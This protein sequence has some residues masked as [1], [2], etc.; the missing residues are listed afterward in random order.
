MKRSDQVPPNMSI[1]I[2]GIR[3]TVCMLIPGDNAWLGQCFWSNSSCT[4]LF[5]STIWYKRKEPPPDSSDNRRR[6]FP[7]T[8]NYYLGKG[9]CNMVVFL[10]S[11]IYMHIWWGNRFY[12]VR[13]AV[14]IVAAQDLSRH[15]HSDVNAL[16]ALSE[17]ILKYFVYSV[18][19]HYMHY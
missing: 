16:P 7:L 12:R 3:C 10:V 9:V 15:A 4:V 18:Q 13:A 1:N 19:L 14:V 5:E 6:N 17:E 8:F 11:W 2:C